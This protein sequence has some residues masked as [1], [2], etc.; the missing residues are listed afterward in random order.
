MAFDTFAFTPTTGWNSTT[1]FPTDPDNETQARQMLQDLHDQTR[2]FIN[3]F[4]A[5][6]SA[7]GAENIGITVTGLASTNVQAAVAEL[8]AKFANYLLL[9]DV[10]QT[11][12]TASDKVPSCAA[13]TA[14]MVS[15]GLGDMLAQVYAANGAT[16]VVDHA[17]TA[18]KLNNIAASLYAL[19]SDVPTAVSD[20][21]NDSGFITDNGS[22]LQWNGL[23][24]YKNAE[25]TN[26]FICT[27]A[28][29]QGDASNTN[30]AST[31]YFSSESLA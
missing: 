10:V 5:L 8:L 30:R 27:K 12:T 18:D 21:T 22:A 15:G 31:I 1:A 28:Q 16:G 24:V 29:W 6:L 20:L 3:T 9:S 13:V 11:V 14:A 7:S 26:P 4:L 19:A 23:R 25:N 17:V 2:D